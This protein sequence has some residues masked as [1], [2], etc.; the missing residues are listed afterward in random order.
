MGARHK[1]EHDGRR[2]SLRQKSPDHP[3]R[4]LHRRHPVEMAAAALDVVLADIDAAGLQ[5][6]RGPVDHRRR[7]D[8]VLGLRD[9]QHRRLD[10]LRRVLQR[11][12]AGDEELVRLD[13]IEQVVGV[14]DL[15]ARFA[16]IVEDALHL[17]C[18]F[19]SG[20]SHAAGKYAAGDAAPG[21]WDAII[22]PGKAIDTD[23]YFVL[24]ADTL[25]NLNTGDPKTTTTGPATIDPD[26]GK[27]YALDFPV[28]TIAD[29]VE[30]QKALV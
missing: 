17:I 11:G 24:S 15:R 4:L 7:E 19:F 23:K 18:H 10:P 8:Q 6:L 2:A 14:G 27:P 20:N 21:Y 22:G 3:F 1:C 13:Q 25:V 29:F 16:G 9:H 26:T 30:V 5:R 12:P 28:V